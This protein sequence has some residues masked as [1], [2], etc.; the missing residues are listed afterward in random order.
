MMVDD[1]SCAGYSVS[2]IRS[3]S[4]DTGI[5]MVIIVGVYIMDKD[6]IYYAQND[7]FSL[8]YLHKK[9]YRFGYIYLHFLQISLQVDYVSGMETISH[10]TGSSPLS[11]NDRRIDLT[12]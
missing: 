7:I 4:L 5:D 6:N 3:D 8:Q 1:L 2:N 10:S 12:K 11:E 9:I